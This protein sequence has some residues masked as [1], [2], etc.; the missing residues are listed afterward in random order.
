VIEP[1]VQ[2]LDT[3]ATMLGML[4]APLPKDSK[5]LGKD[6][7]PLLRGEAFIPHPEIYG[8][9]DLHN[10]GL[11]YLRMVRTERWKLVKHFHENL[12]DELYDLKNDPDETKNLIGAKKAG[13]ENVRDVLK[14]LRAKLL[15][16]QKSIDDPVLSEPRLMDYEVVEDKE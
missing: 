1:P 12:M 16:W 3:F 13:K 8:Q 10:S 11:A 5:Q 2:N 6:L 9:Y 4:G 15:A 7:T 14:D